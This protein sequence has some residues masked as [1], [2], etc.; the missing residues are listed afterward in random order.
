MVDVEKIKELAQEILSMC[1]SEEED[2]EEDAEEEEAPKKGK[3]KD[4]LSLAI[5][6][7]PKKDKKK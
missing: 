2:D 5:A 4:A 1:G 6:F 7:M 3:K